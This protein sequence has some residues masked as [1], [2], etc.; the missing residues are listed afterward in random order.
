MKHKKNQ[1]RI[2]LGITPLVI[3]LLLFPY[4]GYDLF[5]EEGESKSKG[6][7]VEVWNVEGMTCN[8]CALGLEKGLNAVE[9]IV[10][11][12]V[13][14][15]NKTMVCTFNQQ[16]V[17]KDEIESFVKKMGYRAISGGKREVNGES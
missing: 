16:T 1:K 2:L 14:Y 10:S 4:F 12:Q 15:N 6:E 5:A 8:G 13:N 3:A 9:G 11:C 7:E 17:T